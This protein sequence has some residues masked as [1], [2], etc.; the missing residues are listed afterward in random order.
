V[1]LRWPSSLA[2][3]DLLFLIPTSGGARLD[4]GAGVVQVHRRRR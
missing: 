1:G 2:D 4:A 3:R